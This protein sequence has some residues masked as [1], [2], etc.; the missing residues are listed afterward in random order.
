MISRDSPEDNRA[1]VKEHG[2]TFP[3]MLQKQW[4]VS[5]DYAMFAT[6]VGYLIDEAGIIIADLAIGVDGVADLMKRAKAILRDKAN[7][8]NGG[9][10]KRP[11]SG[12]R[13]LWRTPPQNATSATTN[14][15]VMT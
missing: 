14:T 4:E 15:T 5:R 3:I 13:A 7:Q 11:L 1:K 12:F 6:P 2:L 8:A 9:L 10:F